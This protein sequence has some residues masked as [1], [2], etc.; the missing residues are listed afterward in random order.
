[1]GC[2]DG[3]SKPAVAPASRVNAVMAAPDQAAR[4]AASFC[5]VRKDSA[6]ASAFKWP[7]LKGSAP[8]SASG[9]Q[10]VNLWAT[11]CEPCVEEM[12]MLT[13]WQ[14]KLKGSGRDVT[15]RFLSVDGDP[16]LVEKHRSEHPETPA[17]LVIDP[18][19]DLTAWM[20]EIGAGDASTVPIHLFV[21]AASKT[22][23]VRSGALKDTDY[24]AVAELLK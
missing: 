1:M 19:T 18:A 13:A 2:E 21:D 17:S 7:G 4:K 6:S 11:W 14:K 15:M 3:T 5:D 23:C 10:W 24:E 20:G 9:W 16:A 12:P 8:E 22:R